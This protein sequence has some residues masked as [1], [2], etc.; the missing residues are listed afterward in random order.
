MNMNQWKENY[1][2]MPVKK[3]LPVLSFPGCQLV[4]CSVKDVVTNSR[5]QADCMV[6][7]A[8]RYDMAATVGPMDLSVEAEAFGATVVFSD[9]EVPT[10]TD[11]LLDIDEPQGVEDLQVPSVG[12]GRTRIYLE[13][14]A[15]AKKEITDRPILAGCIGPFSLAGRLLDMSNAMIAC[16]E[17]PEMLEALLE[18]ATAFLKQY[19]QAFKDAGADGIVMAEPAAGLLS[20]VLNEEFSVPYVKEIFEAVQDE[21]FICCYHNCGPYVVRQLDDILDTEADI[22]HFGD[23]IDLDD[24]KNKIPADVFFSGNVS[25]VTAFKTGTVKT[26]KEET[27]T[28]LAKCGNMKNY[29]PS[30]GCD[31]PPD[32]SLANADCF[33]ETV[34]AYYK[35]NPHE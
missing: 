10:I 22:Y 2:N 14:I 35:E 24:I 27:Q 23:A 33:F 18:K 25:P 30:S 21:N 34:A 4:G 11:P 17:E 31:I 12:A 20:P 15:L 19:I 28:V 29:I 32:A 7:I 3:P 16:V 9:H 6:Q 1:K 8:K 13:A 5:V 26:M